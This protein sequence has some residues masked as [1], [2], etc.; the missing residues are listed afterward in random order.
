MGIQ[1]AEMMET[2]NLVAW[3]SDQ[4]DEPR[5]KWPYPPVLI[6]GAAQEFYWDKELVN[7]SVQFF[8][9]Q[10]SSCRLL[11][12][13]RA[14]FQGAAQNFSWDTEEI[15]SSVNSFHSDKKAAVGFA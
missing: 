15:N 4:S 2:E 12:W 5:Y 6:L 8:K 7:S 14:L 10:V 11:S 1:P 13:M 9:R 3:N